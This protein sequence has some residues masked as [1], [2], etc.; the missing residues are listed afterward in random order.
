LE[1]KWFWELLEQGKEKDSNLTAMKTCDNKIGLHITKNRW[2]IQ[3]VICVF[4]VLLLIEGVVVCNCNTLTMWM[5]QQIFTNTFRQALSTFHYPLFL[6]IQVFFR[7][8][9][10]QQILFFFIYLFFFFCITE[11]GGVLIN[12]TN[13]HPVIPQRPLFFSIQRK[14]AL[15]YL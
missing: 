13:K 9:K 14:S 4:N 6:L 15:S 8:N 11:S 3:N 1:R 2:I 5:S 12:W 7:Q 10:V